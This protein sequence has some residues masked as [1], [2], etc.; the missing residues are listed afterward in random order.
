MKLK[1]MNKKLAL[2]KSTIAHLDT[3]IM[4]HAKGGN[5]WISHKDPGAC[6]GSGDCTALYCD[7][8]PAPCDTQIQC[9]TNGC[10][11]FGC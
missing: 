1:K 11:V 2:S 5:Q 6:G 7:S 4:D 3:N 8:F 10:S 9:N